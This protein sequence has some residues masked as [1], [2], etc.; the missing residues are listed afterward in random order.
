MSDISSGS[1]VPVSISAGRTG[2]RGSLMVAAVDLGPDLHTVR[3][4]CRSAGLRLTE[5]DPRS[6]IGA[7]V[8]IVGAGTPVPASI[9]GRAIGPY[10]IVVLPDDDAPAHLRHL[11]S[12]RTVVL[13][14]PLREQR[15]HQLLTYLAVTA[16][17]RSLRRI[18]FDGRCTVTSGDLS[19]EVD[20]RE[21][22]LLDLL[23]ARPGVVQRISALPRE[24][25]AN[26]APT[27]ATL[28]RKLASIGSP[29]RVL[30]VPHVGYRLDGIV[31]R[32]SPPPE[33]GADAGSG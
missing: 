8:L 33:S 32:P 4:A 9:A 30:K 2:R 21:A 13:R 26:H 31:E 23:A 3:R 7:T 14:S 6:A 11:R 15:M 12:G 1:A 22:A 24:L 29:V 20:A 5:C 16:P 25:E 18:S 10:T 28:S 17:P 27:A 19:A